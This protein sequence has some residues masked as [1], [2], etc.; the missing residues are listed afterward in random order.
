MFLHED[1]KNVAFI[2]MASGISATAALDFPLDHL[3]SIELVPEVVTAASEHFASWNERLFTDPRSR[4]IRHDGR[5]VMQS[6]RDPLD[7]IICD[8]LHPAQDGTAS[9]YS[10]E[11]FESAKSRLADKGLF[12]LWLPLYQMDETMAGIVLR[13]FTAVFPKA[14][15]V[16]S[17]L[18]PLQNTLGL[19]GSNAG[20]DLSD[21]FIHRRLASG[22][23]RKL[24][25]ESPFFR[26]AANARLLFIGDL[27][28]VEGD[29]IAYPVNTD[30]RPAFVFLGARPVP[31]GEN[32]R[33]LTYLNWFGKRFVN[34]PLPSCVLGDTPAGVVRDGARA[35]NYYFAAAISHLPLGAGGTNPEAR[36]R[37][38]LQQLQFAKSLLPAAEIYPDDLG[39]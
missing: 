28:A 29:F 15:A 22:A 35:G 6:S 21:S 19:I 5:F 11:F 13:T 17:N 37:Q 16:R 27:K 7:V 23:L 9:L 31:P 30:D 20:F 26:S 4:V 18:D 14:I 25:A 39:H 34:A 2:G 1:A 33:A 3:T 24:A 12:C 38:M 32:L 36:G 8:L 10:R